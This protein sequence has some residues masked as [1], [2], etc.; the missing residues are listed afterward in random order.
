M[1]RDCRAC[2]SGRERGT[3]ASAVALI[4]V[5]EDLALVLAVY[6]RQATLIEYVTPSLVI[7]QNAPALSETCYVCAIEHSSPA[8]TTES[9]TTGVNLDTAS[10]D[11]IAAEQESLE[12]VQRHTVA[13]IVRVPAPQTRSRLW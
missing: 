8:Y 4:P 13:Q 2:P 10:F 5:I 12:R 11:Q 6:S 9:V 3:L 1:C 7:E